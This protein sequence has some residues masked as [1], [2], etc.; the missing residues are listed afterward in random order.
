MDIHGT[1][2]DDVF[3]QPKDDS[4][5]N[6][7]LAQRGNDTYRINQGAVLGGA[8]NDVIERLPST[9][10]WRVVQAAY[11]DSPSGIVV[12]L[13]GG[14]AEDGWGTRDTLIGVRDVS[15]SWQGDRI[16]GDGADNVLIVGGGNNT[17]DG[18]DGVDTLWL[19]V[20][21][22]GM[23]L[24]EFT[25]VAS[26]DGKSATV[27]SA[28]HPE[29]KTVAS[30][31]E[32]IGVGY[33]VT[34]SIA[35]FI[36]PEQM[37]TQGLVGGDAQ[38]WNAGKP[39]GS[40]VEVTYGFALTA[41]AAGI[42]AAGFA[43]FDEAQRATVRAIL[44]SLAKST[45]LSFREVANDS[46]GLH[47][48][49][50]QQA[51]TKG[52]GSLPGGAT[53]G[54]VWMDVDSM[55][56]LAP[57]S[58]GYA[59]LLHEIGHAL[60][61]RHPRNVEPGDA[62]TAQWRSEDDST[63]LTVMSQTASSDGLF[64][65]TWGAYDITA[66]RYLYGSKAV[67]TGDTAYLLDPLRFQSQTSIVDDG[68]V[69]TIDASLSLA[70]V[71]IDLQ[72]G[73]MS[74]VGVTAAGVA[75]VNN[76]AI[77]PG[78]WIERAT[79]SDFDDVIVGN[80]LANTLA[81]GKGNDWLDGGAG[82]DSAV[83]EGVRADY[84]IST[85][86]GKVF[87]TA[88]DG[89][90]GFDTLLGIETLVFRD[91]AVVLGATARGADIAID[92]DQN[93]SVA[94]NLPAASDASTVSYKL[95]SAPANGTL[96]LSP[97]GEFTFTPRTGFSTEDSFSYTLTDA[98][99]ASNVYMGFIK[100]RP[101][102]ATLVGSDAADS[103]AGTAGN[104][105]LDAGA[106]NDLLAGSAG[107]DALNG[108]AGL[109]TVRYQQSRAGA[110]FALNGQG[111]ITVGKGAGAGTD[112]LIGVERVLFDNGAV[113]FDLEGS[114][115]Q[116]YRLYQA[117]FDRKPDSGGL[118]FWIYHMD[119][120]LTPVGA[121]AGFMQSAEFAALYGASPSAEQLVTKL[122]NNV[123]HRVPD[124]G[125]FDFWMKALADGTSRAQVLAY[126]ADSPENH[127]QVIGVIQNGI[128]Y[129]PTIA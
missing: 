27:T 17:I 127:A 23:T 41:P 103:L 72:P 12:D 71:A 74:S 14:W 101:I 49:A 4:N 75:A 34:Y 39:L 31:M 105:I 65:S 118:G 35:D 83:F 102:S 42:G 10:W 58:E 90:S 76:L 47:F 95:K 117:A 91:S 78:S 19:P 66:L 64:P 55:R 21:H 37:A 16:Y 30:N 107:F 67:N 82:N 60:G 22:E 13:A 33:Q 6:T 120:G 99:G 63:S 46:A 104:D 38:R 115:G 48:G 96:T 57:G 106:G 11:W 62:Y 53:G 7:Y 93:A 45:G 124:Q 1:D 121:A 88:R 5:W 32:R 56:N 24:D 84:L 73:H 69:D 128:D 114:A 113:A 125:G 112:T 61:L 119:R 20:F 68:G 8:G 89:I 100:V 97:A 9:D 116:A 52:V 109:D 123:L 15:G 87:V 50:S 94:G 40:A 80:A 44:D 25:I 110:T 126:F 36:K 59:A 86:F 81:G 18:R 77:A 2:S 3:V 122:Y 26:I 108:G 70:G 43:P 85:G 28:G 129:I 51:D 54:Q 111:A 98:T 79:G 92:V 29:F